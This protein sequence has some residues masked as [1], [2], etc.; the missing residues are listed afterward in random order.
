MYQITFQIMTI[1]VKFSF[2]NNHDHFFNVAEHNH[3]MT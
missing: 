2:I 1:T 3:G